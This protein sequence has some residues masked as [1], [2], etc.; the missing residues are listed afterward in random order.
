MPI[1]VRAYH[2]DI[3]AVVQREFE[4]ARV[5]PGTLAGGEVIVCK[6]QPA[7]PTQ[8]MRAERAGNRH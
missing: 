3:W 6:T 4:N 2:P 7:L 1:H 8:S 5:F